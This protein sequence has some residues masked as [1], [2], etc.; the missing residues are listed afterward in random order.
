[1]QW[2]SVEGVSRCSQLRSATLMASTALPGGVHI[3]S[4]PD[5]EIGRVLSSTDAG[6]EGVNH[7]CQEKQPVDTS[8]V[9]RGRG[10]FTIQGIAV[11]LDLST[12]TR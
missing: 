3:Q 6:G 10:T 9:T 4:F 12:R 2:V 8:S 5:C 11:S 1:M 7:K